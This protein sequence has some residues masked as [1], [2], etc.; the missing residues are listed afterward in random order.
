MNRKAWSAAGAALL[1]SFAA[2]AQEFPTKP[3][4]IVVA[5]AAG[6]PFENIRP[7]AQFFEKA[8]GRPVLVENRPGAG[9]AVGA[10]YVAKAAPD[11]HTLLY[12]FAGLTAFRALVKDLRFD[13]LKDFAPI[14]TYMELAGGLTTNPQVPAKSIDEFVSYAKTNPGKLNYGSIGRNTTY[15]VI[16]AFARAAGIRMTEIQYSGTAQATTGLLRNDVQMIQATF[17]AALRGQTDGS[18][19]RPLVVVAARR[20]KLFPDIPTAAEK[21]F[22]L[23]RNGWTGLLAPAATAKPVVDRI[24]AEVARF[25]ASVEGQ[26]YAAD[27]GTDLASSTPEQLRQLMESQQKL[28][29]DTAAA[30]GLQPQ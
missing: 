17:N 12:G 9:G 24:A 23:P 6:G 2:Q 19:L 27:Q 10:E 28:W 7:L 3:V 25:A 4:T 21:G 8:W 11:G 29:L 14:S 15:L 5:F 13:P 1:L 30:V 16:E 22:D 20:A 26:K 18:V